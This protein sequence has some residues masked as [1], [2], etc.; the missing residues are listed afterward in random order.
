MP[1][2]LG[3]DE[4]RQALDIAGA[5]EAMEELCRDEAAGQT[6]SSDR[7]HIRL[8]RG[9]LRIL[10]GVLTRMGVLDTRSSTAAATACGTP[11]TCL[12]SRPASRSQ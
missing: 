11:F 2:A 7:I 5:I 3:A 8:P 4:V 12:T 9:F 6:L 10:P 1:L